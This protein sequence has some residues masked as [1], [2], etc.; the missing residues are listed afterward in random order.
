MLKTIKFALILLIPA[1]SFAQENSKGGIYALSHKEKMTLEVSQVIDM[2]ILKD[3]RNG[4]LYDGKVDTKSIYDVMRDFELNSLS[5]KRKYQ[6]GV[7]IRFNPIS[8]N[9]DENGVYFRFDP[10][11]K[12][13]IDQLNFQAQVGDALVMNGLAIGNRARDQ[14]VEESF[15]RYDLHF[16]NK[17]LLNNAYRSYAENF[18]EKEA[19]LYCSLE[20]G[21]YRYQFCNC[22]PF[23]N[24]YKSEAIDPIYSYL[25][26]ESTNLNAAKAL[27][28]VLTFAELL[29]VDSACFYSPLKIEDC[30]KSIN[31]VTKNKENVD[32]ATK[33]MAVKLLNLGYKFK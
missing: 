4:F 32:K 11:D 31:F 22:I 1:F 7:Y 13:R 19:W 30:A 23:V 16:N 8:I 10:S 27:L 18:S 9:E 6:N 26:K 29:P 24:K 12:N 5:A 28:S 20:K 21:K 33:K 15:K 25:R 14:F 2:L 3:G 17:V